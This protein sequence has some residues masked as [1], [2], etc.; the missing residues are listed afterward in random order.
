LTSRN[1]EGRKEGRKEGKKQSMWWE[2]KFIK[3]RERRL[4]LGARP[5]AQIARGHGTPLLVYSRSQIRA[6]YEAL[7]RTFSRTSRIP[8]RVC[9]AMKANPHREILKLLR[10]L[11]AWVDAVSPGEVEAALRAGFSPRRIL[12]TGTSLG[13]TDLRRVFRV[14][15]LTVNI[16]A[17]E[18]LELMQELKK[19]EFQKKTI[20]VSVRWNPGIGRGF[21]PRAIT[22]GARSSDGTPVKFGVEKSKVLTALKMATSAGFLPVGLHQHLGSGWVDEDY[23]VV[24][25]A[26]D[27]MVAMAARAEK[28]GFR[29]EFLD[30]GGG[31]GPRYQE[32]QRV[33]PLP[34]YASHISRRIAEA[35]LRIQ[36]IAVEPGKYLVA[37]AGVL[38]LG[39]EYLKKSYG[40]L[41]ACVN[42][43][44]YNSLPRPAIYPEA[45]HQ[46][47]NC[48]RVYGP[49]MRPVTVAGNLCETGDVFGKEVPMPVP[50]RGDVLAVLGAGAYGRSM[51]SN[52]NLREMPG[53]LF[54]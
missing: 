35:G 42:S 30:F 34:N 3:V 16:D 44:T 17:L 12:F 7:E 50:Q 40:Q 49:K 2:N 48:G 4:Y 28:E 36:A 1:K 39:V 37:D 29:L 51:A 38:L 46:V 54:T 45:R 24:S 14:D 41:F 15:G 13:L 26:V 10:R 43:G 32:R 9:Y 20:R 23:G 8:L 5:A 11:G 52:F 22:A 33:F 6:N 25:T 21:N 27:R 31:F 18:Q 47:V 53:E 19:N